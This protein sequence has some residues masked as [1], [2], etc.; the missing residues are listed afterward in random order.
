MAATAFDLRL[1]RD[2]VRANPAPTTDQTISVA[3]Q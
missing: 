2:D 1:S 3:I